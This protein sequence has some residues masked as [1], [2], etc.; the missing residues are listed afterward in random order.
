M[1]Q[2]FLRY[3]YEIRNKKWSAISSSFSAIRPFL[4]WA[5]IL[6]LVIR[7][8]ANEHSSRIKVF[9]VASSTFTFL[10]FFRISNN[11]VVF[12]QMSKYIVLYYFHPEI[13]LISWTSLITKRFSCGKINERTSN[14]STMLF[15]FSRRGYR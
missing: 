1:V 11:H 4:L 14:A 9:T 12:I 3:L 6:N 8:G 7:I 5:I 15:S 10:H 2:G 13:T